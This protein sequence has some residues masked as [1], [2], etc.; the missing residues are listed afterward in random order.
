MANC[1]LTG[2]LVD[3]T[4]SPIQGVPVAFRP[5]RGRNDVLFADGAA[6]GDDEHVEYTGEEGEFAIS[7]TQG[8][9]LVIRIDS[10]DVHRQVTVPAQDTCTLEE[11]LN[12][13]L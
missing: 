3:L 13:D 7:L 6:L 4:G 1:I 11:L 2:R 12:A 9:R 10:V 5:D 8:L